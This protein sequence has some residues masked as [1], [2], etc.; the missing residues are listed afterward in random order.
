MHDLGNSVFNGAHQVP[1]VLI[2]VHQHQIPQV[3]A[4]HCQQY[5]T[6]CYNIVKFTMLCME[7]VELGVGAH[8]FTQFR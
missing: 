1:N 7:L 5:M 4:Q 2:H 8:E 3:H 6:S